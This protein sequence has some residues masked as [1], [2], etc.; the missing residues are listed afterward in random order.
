MHSHYQQSGT[1]KKKTKT[2]M[3]CIDTSYPPKSTVHL[4]VHFNEVNSVAHSILDKSIMTYIHHYNVIQS[5]FTAHKTLHALCIH[6]PFL[7][8]S[9]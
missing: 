4:R 5:I 1:L 2:G 8:N 6:L 9:W 7:P 3:N